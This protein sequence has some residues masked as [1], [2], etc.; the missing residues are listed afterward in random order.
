MSKIM[1]V[2]DNK[3]DQNFLEKVLFRLD[4][5]VISMKKGLEITE[6]LID[7]FP[8]VVFASTLGKNEKI[9]SALGKI[10][11]VRGKPK[12]VFV[13]QEKESGFLSQEQK[14][15]IDGVLY[16]P[17][18]PFKLIDLLASTTEV[19]IVELRKRYNE[20]LASDRG[21]GGKPGLTKVSGNAGTD[22]YGSTQVMGKVANTGEDDVT[23]NVTGRVQD[24]YIKPEPTEREKPSHESRE[25]FE[26]TPK[27]KKLPPDT[28]DKEKIETKQSE[29]NETSNLIHDEA[30]K[31]K[32][33]EW[34]KKLQ[35][36]GPP[37]EPID[38]QALRDKQ[39]E[40]AKKIHEEPSIKANRKHFLK[41]LFGMSPEDVKK[42]PS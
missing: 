26:E 36:E 24:T 14:R 42:K 30:R 7:H 31:K 38:I 1:L 23:Y 12:L 21:G 20:M 35:K 13:K 11:E 40:Q 10:K 29:S 28:A 25:S 37:P 8:D 18:D 19:N 22:D 9:L 39:A 17:V 27:P 5:K 33:D 16:S 32:Y 41:T 4:Y 2:L 15:I 6:Q 3:E 34:T